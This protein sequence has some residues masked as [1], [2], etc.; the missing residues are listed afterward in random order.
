MA[1]F[2]THVARVPKIDAPLLVIGLGGTGSD[3]LL[4]IKSE[5]AQRLVLD[6]NAAGQ[7][8]DRPPRTAYLEID[9][10]S[11]VLRNRYH[12]ARIDMN[13]EWIDLSCDIRYV[14]G[15]NGDRL[16]PNI[17]RWLDRRFYT[18][19]DLISHAATDGAGTYRQLSRL[20][21]FQ[22]ALNIVNKLTAVMTNL[23]TV[24]PGAVVGK[25]AI[26]V[27]VVAGLSGGTGS[28]TFMDL[29]YLIRYAAQKAGFDVK[30][31][32]YAVTPDVTINR[33]AISDPTKQDI[34]KTN[35]FAAMKELDYWMGYNERR[36]PKVD[37]EE[38]RVDYGSGIEISWNHVPYDDV[39]LL[40]AMNEQGA[41]LENAYNVVMNS[42]AEVLLFQMAGEAETRDRVGQN[43]DS[44]EDTFTFQSQRSNEHAYR[45]QIKKPYGENYAYRTIGAYSNLGE[46]RSKVS[47]E[48]D[49]I[50]DD[51]HTFSLGEEQ[52]PVM[53][54]TDPNRFQEPFEQLIGTLYNDFVTRTAY[55]DAMFSKVPPYDLNS[56]KTI[57]PSAA[58]HGLFAGWQQNLKTAIPGIKKEY[59]A[60]MFDTFK[61]M[62]RA[63]IKGHGPNALKTMLE[64]PKTGFLAYLDG[65]VSS[66]KYQ[67]EAYHDEK[68][69]AQVSAAEQ[70]TLMTQLGNGIAGLKDL[71]AKLPRTFE[72]YLGQTRAM[73]EKAQAEE[74]LGLLAEVLD[75]LKADIKTN[76]V[77]KTLP[78]TIAALDSIKDQVSQDVKDSTALTNSTHLVN[79]DEMQENIRKQYQAE[80]HQLQF[81]NTVLDKVS[82]VVLSA[83]DITNEDG[84][85][86]YVIGAL[87]TMISD[88]FR[89]INDTTLAT[90]L[91]SY[92][93]VNADGV[94]DHVQSD[95]CPEL[96]RGASP[97]FAVASAYGRLDSM[98]SV[99][100]SYISVPENA[101][102]V[103][104]G[105]INYIN[106]THKYSGAVI[107]HS[108]ISD[109]IF[110]MN[111][112]AGL[113]LCAYYYLTDYEQVYMLNRNAR[114]GTH[115]VKVDQADLD[116]LNEKR[117]V[118]N[119]WQFLPSPNPVETLGG[120][121]PN[122]VLV[123]RAQ[124]EQKLLAE[125]EKAGVLVLNTEG[126]I[127]EQYW[128]TLHLFSGNNGQHRADDEIRNALNS[129]IPWTLDQIEKLDAGKMNPDQA[130]EVLKLIT[131]A[132]EVLKSRV[133]FNQSGNSKETEQ[134]AIRFAMSAGDAGVFDSD[135]KVRAASFRKAVYYRLTKRPIL[136][137]EIE[138]QIG[139]Q[140]EFNEKIKK[141]Q[142]VW[143]EWN[144]SG[145][146]WI[147]Y[148]EKVRASIPTMS[149]LLVY[150]FAKL[151]L[152]SV[153]Y[154]DEM[155]NFRNSV[156]DA[157]NVLMNQNT[158]PYK[159]EPWVNFIPLEAR[160]VIWY[161]EQDVNE[162]PLRTLLEQC[163]ELSE[164][165]MNLAGT[166][167]D[168][169]RVRG[170]VKTAD[171]LTS[172]FLQKQAAL[173]AQ[174]KVVPRK[175]YELA[176]QV[177][178]QLKTS[179]Q[180]LV[181]PFVG[182]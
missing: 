100:C 94:S 127:F 89:T 32:L 4:R 153:A 59:H 53:D 117:T 36:D 178:D 16:A 33:Q 39:T 65:K 136:L 177:M 156:T 172:T 98:N 82:D 122:E 25:K 42:M 123:D 29:S 131:K 83:T 5:F 159:D 2:D 138:R 13:E 125:A 171:T 80:D 43:N 54:G 119:D 8:L 38:Y 66:Y 73:Y 81:R 163:K 93:G 141:L 64:N 86:D 75:Q 150:D 101:T 22:N 31:E 179:I 124:K 77:D 69:T 57:D 21:L 132:D 161:N 18:D 26:N 34:Y 166:P 135:P 110:W 11:T 55:N 44:P 45:Q 40:C 7:E 173:R 90:M 176:L 35:S 111:V 97:H 128:A 174:S 106:R 47:M 146:E 19:Q 61:D 70:H 114:P 149:K 148:S 17:K 37:E 58:P 27:V 78:V 144:H 167:E 24:T 160:L 129:S 137:M 170:Y 112:V 9:T 88:V 6:K 134:Q 157:P 14:L 109:R 3:G 85:A 147:S 165:L 168:L 87:N 143:D 51:L 15:A 71:L 50:F 41:L 79:L 126:T 121:H 113:P 108:A 28:G 115:L 175:I 20:M 62:V 12:G 95:I 1:Y 49:L 60:R 118:L 91:E 139:L 107:K 162:E 48:A 76:I 96:E 84:A 164:E 104:Q 133:A 158:S 155:G 181:A 105:V 74:G 56:I 154:K 10:D 130:D 142:H 102:E 68:N 63:Y 30:V 182:L 46:Q 152:N 169:E 120:D 151:M 180:G 116:R 99:L 103:R 145:D 52:L 23:R 92:G 72:A 140:E 67:A